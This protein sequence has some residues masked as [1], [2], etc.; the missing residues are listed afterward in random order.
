MYICN[1]STLLYFCILATGIYL[2]KSSYIRKSLNSSIIS[3]LINAVIILIMMYLSVNILAYDS[4]YCSWIKLEE[5]HVSCFYINSVTYRIV[6]T[7]DFTCNTDG[8]LIFCILYFVIYCIGAFIL[9][10]VSY[11]NFTDFFVN[12]YYTIQYLHYKY[13]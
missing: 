5:P 6:D 8:N 2:D 4:R 13:M 9:P 7:H 3:L 12:C 1:I 10:Y 11:K